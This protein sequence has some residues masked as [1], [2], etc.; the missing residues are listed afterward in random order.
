MVYT[1]AKT[2]SYFELFLHDYLLKDIVIHE[3][4]YINRTGLVF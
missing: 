4:L 1:F 3:T 2:Y